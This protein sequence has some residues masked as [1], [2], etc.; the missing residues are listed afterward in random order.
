M[1]T[2]KCISL[3]AIII[4]LLTISSAAVADDA[5]YGAPKSLDAQ[6]QPDS[7][8]AEGILE[9]SKYGN[10]KINLSHAQVLEAFDYG[11]ILTASF[12]DASVDVPLGKSFSDVD[13]GCP[14][15]FLQMDG[16]TEETELAVNMGNFAEA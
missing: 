3:I 14:G 2:L 9:I 11:D 10:V 7:V 13:F 8:T 16:E 12:G 1:R 15:L 6:S 4:L 5:S